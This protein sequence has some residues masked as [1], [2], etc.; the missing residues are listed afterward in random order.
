MISKG[1]FDV[2]II[3]P[4]YNNEENLDDCLKSIVNQTMFEKIEIICVNDGST[5]GSQRIIQNYVNTNNNIVLLNQEN[6]GAGLARNKGIESAQGHYVMFIDGDDFLAE[7]DSVEK[8]YNGIS[9]N[10]LDV[11]C[12]NMLRLYNGR[13]VRRF[14]TRRKYSNYRYEGVIDTDKFA[15]PFIHFL[16]IYKRDFLLNKELRYPDRRRGQDVAFCAE[17][18]SKTSKIYHIDYPIYVH[19]IRGNK[20]VFE[21]GK[22]VDY[23]MCWKNVLEKCNT[24]KKR[25]MYSDVASIELRVF[26]LLG[27]YKQVNEN[28]DW[29]LVEDINT[30]LRS[31]GAKLLLNSKEWND[32]GLAYWEEYFRVFTYRVVRCLQK[33]IYY[34]LYGCPRQ[35]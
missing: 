28:H 18:L 27:W 11:C 20:R 5:D 12:G 14:E 4:I 9:D 1:K 34:Y 2:S 24:Q 23:A 21:Y 15:F 16:C 3:I 22:A 26:A 6:M 32:K 13:L 29:D 35:L 8:L 31:G 7:N 17:V 30:L 25:S 10:D 33:K 19:R